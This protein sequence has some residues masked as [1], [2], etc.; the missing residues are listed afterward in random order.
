MSKI[1]QVI[2]SRSPELENGVIVKHY[3]IGVFYESRVRRYLVV[4]DCAHFPK[5][6]L[7]FIENCNYTD[8]QD[9]S[10]VYHDKERIIPGVSKPI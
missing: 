3:A 6:V 1:V 8:V 2:V 7:E 4:R 5:N 10:I 9:Y